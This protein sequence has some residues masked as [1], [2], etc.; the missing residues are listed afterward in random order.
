LSKRALLQLKISCE[1]S[2]PNC[3]HRGHRSQSFILAPAHPSLHLRITYHF[4]PLSYTA[5]HV[6]I[7]YLSDSM[8]R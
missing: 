1:G 6:L 7:M 5:Q 4:A 3:P 2:A 8:S